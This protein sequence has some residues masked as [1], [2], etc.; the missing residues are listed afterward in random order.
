MFREIFCVQLLAPSLLGLNT[1][2]NQDACARNMGDSIF[3]F[4]ADDWLT[5]A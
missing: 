4:C 3:L 2:S 5:I 1:L